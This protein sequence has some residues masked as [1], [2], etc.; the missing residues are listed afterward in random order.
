MYNTKY[1]GSSPPHPVPSQG[2]ILSPSWPLTH[3]IRSFHKFL[4]STYLMWGTACRYKDTGE[5]TFYHA[6][7]DDKDKQNLQCAWWW[8]RMKSVGFWWVGGVV[9]KDWSWRAF[10]F[11]DTLLGMWSFPHPD[12]THALSSAESSP[13]DHEGSLWKAFLIRR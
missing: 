6:E 7:A 5:L 12:G 4:L 1:L 10:F 13:L 11:L 8:P 3:H 9:E 2:N